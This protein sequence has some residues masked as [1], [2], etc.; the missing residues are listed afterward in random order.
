MNIFFSAVRTAIVVAT[1][2]RT[3]QL[4]STLVTAGKAV[5]DLLDDQR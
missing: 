1:D 4:V 2:P 3:I 5:L